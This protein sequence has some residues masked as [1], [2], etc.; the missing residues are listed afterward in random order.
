MPRRP[1]QRVEIVCPTCGVIAELSRPRGG[2]RPKFCDCPTP[3]SISPITTPR[4]CT[5]CATALNRYNTGSLGGP[6]LHAKAR[7]RVRV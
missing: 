1:L 4:H 6:C 7:R 3:Q 5:E 2:T